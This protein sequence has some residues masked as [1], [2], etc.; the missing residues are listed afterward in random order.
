MLNKI[1][2]K[3]SFFLKIIPPNY[4]Y[5]YLLLHCLKHGFMMKAIP[6]LKQTGHQTADILMLLVLFWEISRTFSKSAYSYLVDQQGMPLDIIKYLET[7]LFSW[8]CRSWDKRCLIQNKMVARRKTT[9]FQ[10]L[11]DSTCLL[12][13]MC[14]ILFLIIA[15]SL[16]NSL[17]KNNKTLFCMSSI[18]YCI[19]RMFFVNHFRKR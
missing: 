2:D 6:Y 1:L 17:Y 9:R 14:S 13:V 7:F 10:T 5:F 16:Q 19:N 4:I 8:S 12:V 3:F 15:K 11:V 18:T